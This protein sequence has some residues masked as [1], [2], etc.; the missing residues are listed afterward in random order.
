VAQEHF[1]SNLIR[2]RIAGLARGWGTGHGPRALL[3]TP[4]GELHE[5]AL[6]M[7]GIALDRAGWRIDYLG[8]STPMDDLVRVADELRPDL[9]VLAATTADRF[10]DIRSGLRT[11]SR[12]VPLALAGSGADSALAHDVGARFLDGDPVTAAAL[13][14]GPAPAEGDR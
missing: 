2:G 9:V 11:L 7:F 6:M 3:A 4:P 14:S 5:L 10:A 13:V 8:V 12:T 1:A